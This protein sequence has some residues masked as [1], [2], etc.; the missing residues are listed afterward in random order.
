M[1]VFELFIL[2]GMIICFSKRT[3]G[4]H[5]KFQLALY[6][7]II[8]NIVDFDCYKMKVWTDFRIRV[9]TEIRYSSSYIISL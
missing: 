1:I 5:V 4:G 6:S 2:I 7:L 9:R 3:F 8:S